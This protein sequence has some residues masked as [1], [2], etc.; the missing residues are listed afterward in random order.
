M[1]DQMLPGRLG[2]YLS[3]MHHGLANHRDFAREHHEFFEHMQ[4]YLDP[5]EGLR[6]LD[7]GCGK[8]YWLSLL[9]A[10]VGAKVTGVDTEVVEPGFRTGK[11]FGILQRNGME[12]ALRTLVWDALFA[13][14]YY[15]ALAQ[16]H[17]GALAFERVDLKGTAGRGYDFPADTFDL[18]VSHE[19]FEHIADLPAVLADLWRV[20]K[21]GARTY[22]YI[23]NY[24]SLSGGHHIA[25]KYPDREP[26][27]VVPPWDHLRA[28]KFPDIPSWLNGLREHEY[29][30]VFD[31]HFD[32]L[33]WLTG[34]REGEAL[35]TPE[36][37]AELSA[38]SER[39]LLTKGFTVVATPKKATH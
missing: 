30:Q 37:R 5:I 19:V 11:Y 14:P 26:S 3:M 39:E 9:L 34:E 17:G 1:P 10:T 38:Y 21:P 16:R 32:I 25:W 7:V 23:H 8:S 6:I 36:L 24:T 20:M 18:V 29:R 35:L 33:D 12:R 22:I 15:R 27:S 31:E 2:L 4:R 13:R 28:R